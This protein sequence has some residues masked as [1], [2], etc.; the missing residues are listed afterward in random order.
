M[1]GQL[2]GVV[3][4]EQLS[5]MNKQRDLSMYDVGK[6]DKHDLKE[7][8]EKIPT[9]DFAYTLD[10]Q[11]GDGD[12]LLFSDE[13][14]FVYESMDTSIHVLEANIKRLATVLIE[15]FVHDETIE[16]SL[17]YM[18]WLINEFVPKLDHEIFEEPEK[19]IDIASYARYAL[20]GW[21]VKL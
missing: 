9:L 5:I 18:G 15:D 10:D 14:A 8:Q 6:L 19:Y 7:L 13:E 4:S 2:F 3:D 11:D 21:G 20:N 16:E 17:D 12:L 1:A